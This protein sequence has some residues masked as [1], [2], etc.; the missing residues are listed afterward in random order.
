MRVVALR[1]ESANAES[2]ETFLVNE[3]GVGRGC[4]IRMARACGTRWR[5][6][7]L[8]VLAI[9]SGRPGA[10]CAPPHDALTGID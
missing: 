1:H 10:P 5:L 2:I 4:A 7:A 3:I 8:G 6:V 9:L